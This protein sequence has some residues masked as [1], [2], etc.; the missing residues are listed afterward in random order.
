MPDQTFDPNQSLGERRI[1]LQ[2]FI[3]LL[4]SLIQQSSRVSQFLM[5][6]SCDSLAAGYSE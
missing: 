6:V 1:L 3:V 5:S 2:P 4:L